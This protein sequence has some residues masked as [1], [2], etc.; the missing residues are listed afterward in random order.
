MPRGVE[1]TP[2]VFLEPVFRGSKSAVFVIH[3]RRSSLPLLRAPRVT[4][5]ML[6]GPHSYISL[7]VRFSVSRLDLSIFRIT[8]TTTTPIC[9]RAYSQQSIPH[10][11][12]T[13]RYFTPSLAAPFHI[14]PGHQFGGPVQVSKIPS[15]WGSTI[16]KNDRSRKTSGLSQKEQK[17]EWANTRCLSLGSREIRFRLGRLDIPTLRTTHDCIA[18][19]PIHQYNHTLY[20]RIYSLNLQD[21]N[22]NLRLFCLRDVGVWGVP[23]PR[24]FPHVIP[25]TLG[26]QSTLANCMVATPRFALNQDHTAVLVPPFRSRSRVAR[27]S[28]SKWAAVMVERSGPS[29][30]PLRKGQ[31][32][33]TPPVSGTHLRP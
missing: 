14:I 22:N 31:T 28:S 32:R 10:S 33:K 21:E 27:F 23:H 18:T 29:S 9:A 15:I 4:S 13:E 20:V 16:G 1:G 17:S 5:S 11:V 30:G 3:R 8:F 24:L 25:V 12:E 6:Y 19:M 26:S 7:S 2:R